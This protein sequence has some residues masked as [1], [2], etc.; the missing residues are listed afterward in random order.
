MPRLVSF[1]SGEAKKATATA[2]LAVRPII[3]I[4]TPPIASATMQHCYHSQHLSSIAVNRILTNMSRHTFS[5]LP[6]HLARKNNGMVNVFVKSTKVPRPPVV[7]MVPPLIPPPSTAI[8]GMKPK[9]KNQLKQQVKQAT[10]AN[11]RILNDESVVQV[12]ENQ[13]Q[14]YFSYA[15]N[16]NIPITSKLKIVLPGED[17]PRGIWPAFRMM[18]RAVTLHKIVHSLWFFLNFTFISFLFFNSFRMNMAASSNPTTTA[19]TTSL[20]RMKPRQ[21]HLPT[22]TIFRSFNR[23]SPYNILTLP[24]KSNRVLFLHPPSMSTPIQTPPTHCFVRIDK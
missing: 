15:G 12:Q 2:M 4:G 21:S 7:T 18:V 11:H 13:Q 20:L 24:K 23:F 3:G 22:S 9:L 5:S 8:H 14:H 16:A 6:H 19:T 10:N 1:K 17:V